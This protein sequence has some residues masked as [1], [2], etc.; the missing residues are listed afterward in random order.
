MAQAPVR[1]WL[2]RLIFH[3]NAEHL[4]E[5]V[6]QAVSSPSSV[7]LLSASVLPED[8]LCPVISHQLSPGPPP[9]DLSLRWMSPACPWPCHRPTMPLHL[10]ACAPRRLQAIFL[11]SVQKQQ[12]LTAAISVA[13]GWVSRC[14]SCLLPTGHAAAALVC[15][16]WP[17]TWGSGSLQRGPHLLCPSSS[18]C[19]DTTKCY[20]RTKPANLGSNN[21]SFFT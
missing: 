11:T 19:D 9:S 15:A 3:L 16:H 4:W 1:L 13:P 2:G 18:P 6:L 12:L 17:D 21:W 5:N 10:V 8:P 7:R 20:L 14:P